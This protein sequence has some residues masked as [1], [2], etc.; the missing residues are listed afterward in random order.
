MNYNH[1]KFSKR[2][3]CIIDENNNSNKNNNNDKDT[4][5]IVEYLLQ[6]AYCDLISQ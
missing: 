1:R 2:G 3:I 6:C 5:I 4:I